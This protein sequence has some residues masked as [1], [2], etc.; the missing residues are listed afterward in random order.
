MEVLASNPLNPVPEDVEIDTRRIVELWCD[1]RSRFGSGGPFLF[2]AFSAAD[3]MYAPVASRFRTYLPDLAP[4]GDDGT[5]AA[6][7]ATIFATPEMGE[8]VAGA[9][10]EVAAAS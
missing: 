3:A 5:A 2:G 10:A 1:C 8:W 7:M 9:R 4:F 6:Y